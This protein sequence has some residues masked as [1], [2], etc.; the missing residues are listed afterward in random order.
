M[1]GFIVPLPAVR[2]MHSP[3]IEDMRRALTG[4]DDDGPDGGSPVIRLRRKTARHA[5]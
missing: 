2:L 5:G 1:L 4:E 3:D